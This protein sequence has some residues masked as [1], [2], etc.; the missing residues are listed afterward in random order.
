M[1]SYLRGVHPTSL[2]LSAQGLH[3]FGR[4]W[5]KGRLLFQS[6]GLFSVVVDC[7]GICWGVFWKG[8]EVAFLL[9]GIYQSLACHAH[10]H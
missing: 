10:T 1:V 7:F 4:V 9:C 8:K 6:S 2:V 3:S 5:D